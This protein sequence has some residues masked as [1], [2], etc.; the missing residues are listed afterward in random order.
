MA[1]FDA[2]II[3]SQKQVAEAQSKISEL[4][5]KIET[6][7]AGLKTGSGLS[8]DVANATLADVQSHADLMNANIAELIM[9]LDDVTS[10]FSQGLRRDA[11][12]DRVG[13]L[14][15]HVQR[16]EIGFDAG[17]TSARGVGRRQAAG[18]DRQVGHHREAAAGAAGHAEHAEGAGRDEPDRNAGRPRDDGGRTGGGAGR[19]SR[20]WTRRSSSWRTRSASNRTR[21][22]GRGWRRNWR[23]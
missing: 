14:R 17:G 2:Q 1:D 9:G 4:T 11:V 15:R 6:A 8:I 13:E 18:P 7:Q 12:E 21:R 20:R 3:E 16:C 10:G 23:T 5:A 22:R 19:R